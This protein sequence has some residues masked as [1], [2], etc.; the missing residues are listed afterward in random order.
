MI[1]EKITGE[2]YWII[3]AVL[4]LNILQRKHHHKATKK[5]TAT[6]I[7]AVLV[8]VLNM[9]L[10]LIIQFELP[11]WLGVPSLIITL[12]I[13]YYFKD[14]IFIF[15]FRCAECGERLTFNDIFYNDDN[16][17]ESCRRRLHPEQ[18]PDEPEEIEESAETVIDRYKDARD[19]K[20]ID[21]D[22]WEPKEKAVICY[23]F[24]D[25][26]VLLINKKTGLGSGLVNAPGGRIE[27]S[28]T[29]SEAA[30]R[31]TVEETGLTPQNLKEVGVLNFQFID[32]YSLKGYVFFADS[33]TG[34]M[35]ETDEADPFWVSVEDI[36]YD[37]MWEDDALWLPKT[38]AGTYIE[39]RFIFDDR[40]MLSNEILER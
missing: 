30:V 24:Q 12:I 28:E 25:G 11:Q 21:W 6:L 40:T 33:C 9:F 5:R 39:G 18:Y 14:K 13:G 22:L 2:L 38:I 35:T 10:A 31:E 37:R 19:V 29:A 23:I 20:E 27:D 4:F 34:T 3:L 26:K 8:L 15:K 7:I 17:C 1:L 32:G 16:L 36:P